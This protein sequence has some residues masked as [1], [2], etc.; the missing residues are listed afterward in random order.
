[1]FLRNVRKLS[2]Y[3]ASYTGYLLL[4]WTETESLGSQTTSEP[5]VPVPDDR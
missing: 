3:T 1:M 2:Y 4:Q 5:I